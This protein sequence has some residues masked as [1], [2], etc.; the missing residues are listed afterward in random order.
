MKHARLPS[1][2]LLRRFAGIA[3]IL[4][5]PIATVGHS[6]EPVYP[7]GII[8]YWMLDE[9]GG[10]TAFDSIRDA[11][12]T[13]YGATWTTGQI[14]GALQFAGAGTYVKAVNGTFPISTVEAWVKL[15]SYPT[16]YRYGMV[17]AA[18]IRGVCTFTEILEVDRSGN[19]SFYHW[20]GVDVRRPV[21]TTRLNLGEWYHLAATV[22]HGS[23]V[24][25]Y[26]NGHAEGWVATNWTHQDVQEV[27]FS[28]AQACWGD[29]YSHDPYYGALD[30][31]AIYTR[32]LPPEEIQQ[33]Y[34]DGLAGKGLNRLPIADAGADQS[35]AVDSACV[36]SVTLDG[37]ASSD[38]D[39]DTLTYTWTGPFGEASGAEPR[40]QLGC[41]VHEVT[42]AVDDGRGGTAADTVVVSV[43]DTLPPLFANVPPPI[44]AECAGGDGTAVAVPVPDAVDNCDGVRPVVGNAPALFPLGATTVTFVAAD[45]ALNTSEAFTTVTVRDTLAPNL[46][47]LAASPS[48]LWPPDH[49]MW[50]VTVSVSARD[51]CSAATCQ[52]VS[53]TS[54]EPENGLG[55]GDT[56]PDWQVT[57]PL[58]VDLRAERSGKGPGRSYTIVV[59]CTDASGNPAERSVV[60]VVPKSAGPAR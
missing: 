44:V 15:D 25:M 53:V 60:V 40:V 49:R 18:A 32:V 26:V 52:V 33:H 22:Q 29:Y 19:A 31:V 59:R 1:T 20:D 27:G 57:G 54:S 35:A 51:V 48:L 21:S 3:A 6:L 50:A 13:V 42:L 55:D 14:N 38:P 8:S 16:R 17:A 9:G 10:S 39:L 37:S 46:T 7:D 43:T 2:A 36:A 58:S 24:T 47:E 34:Q 30:E 12:G 4:I 28:Y 41:G 11:D 56:S 45:T 23:G 5:L